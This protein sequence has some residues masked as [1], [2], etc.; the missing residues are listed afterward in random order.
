MPNI[1]LPTSRPCTQ[2]TFATKYQ[3]S[4]DPHIMDV[5]QRG[6]PTTSLLL[7]LKLN[8]SGHTPDT[9]L[10]GKRV[11]RLVSIFLPPA[12]TTKQENISFAIRIYYNMRSVPVDFFSMYHKFTRYVHRL[13]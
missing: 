5:I 9:T 8:P 13:F 6:L 7:P 4:S 2:V 3:H 1:N 10:P 11:V 12:L